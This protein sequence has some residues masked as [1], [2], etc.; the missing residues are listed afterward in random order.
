MLP[1][2]QISHT[3]SSIEE[4]PACEFNSQTKAD[5]GWRWIEGSVQLDL[6]ISRSVKSEN[7][8]KQATYHDAR[9]ER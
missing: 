9:V 4:R 2:L 1:S 3:P 5:T 6:R 8:N 7:Q